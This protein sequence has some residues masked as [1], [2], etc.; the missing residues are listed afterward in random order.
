MNTV[1]KTVARKV[2]AAAASIARGRKEAVAEAALVMKRSVEQQ[3][4]RAT[5]DGRLSGVGRS[6]AKL[7]VRFDLKGSMNPTALLRALGPWQLIERKTSAHKIR[8]RKRRGKRAIAFGG[9]A[10][11]WAQHPG[12]RG[13]E[14]WAKGIDAGIKPA[15]RVLR[16][17]MVQAVT[18][19]FR[20]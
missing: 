17:A 7:G 12:T 10:R 9:I 2:N 6:G 5:G 11:A 8:P 1:S 19:G 14:P 3:R 4:D 20:T 16:S 15:L 18:K 13:K